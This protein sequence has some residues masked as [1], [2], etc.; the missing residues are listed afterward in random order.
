MTNIPLDPGFFE[1]PHDY[2]NVFVQGGTEGLVIVP[3]GKNYRT[4]FVE[5]ATGNSFIRGEGL[6]L[7][8]ADDACWAKLQAFLECTQ[9]LWEAR[10]YRNGGGFCKLCGQFG[11]RVFTAEQLDIRCTVCGIPTFHTMTGDEMSE[12]TRC[13]A[14]DPKWPYFVGYLQASPTRRQDETSRAM[15][16]RLN[17]VANY[18]AP[19]D[20]DALEWAYANLDMTRAPRK[21]TP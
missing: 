1:S 6:T 10:G 5:C 21:E 4:A 16:T 17:K 2:G 19:E 3:G 11:A 8:E 13:E 15:Y 7:A 20:P 14:H 12:D 18:G 9:H